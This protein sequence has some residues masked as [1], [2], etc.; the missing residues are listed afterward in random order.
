MFRAPLVI[1][2]LL[3]PPVASA[4]GQAAPARVQARLRPGQTVRIRLADGQRLEG[5]LIA[6]DSAPPVFHFLA[7]QPAVPVTAID[8]LWVRGH[9]SGTCALV[10]GIVVGGASFVF[11]GLL[12]NALSE[13]SGCQVWGTVILL[14]VGGAAGGALLGAAV[15]SLIPKWRRL[16]TN[17]VAF[18]FGPGL[19]GPTAA[20]RVRF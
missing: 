17:R 20:V 19:T 11:W 3:F 7:P 2:G 18:S 10:G 5:R 4:L 8:S 9:A 6:V 16:D 15:G 13:G 1:V 12:C 14:S